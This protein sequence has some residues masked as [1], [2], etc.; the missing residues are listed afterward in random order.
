M[1]SSSISPVPDKVAYYC[2]WGSPY[3]TR[4]IQSTNPA[5]SYSQHI[6]ID[7]TSSHWRIRW[8]FI[9][10]FK[11][12]EITAQWQHERCV[13]ALRKKTYCQGVRK[14]PS[15]R[16]FFSGNKASSK[17]NVCN[18][19]EMDV[20]IQAFGVCMCVWDAASLTKPLTQFEL[21]RAVVAGLSYFLAVPSQWI[22]R[23]AGADE[24][25]WGRHREQ[26][27]NHRNTTHHRSMAG[28][29]Q[30]QTCSK[31]KL[32]LLSPCFMEGL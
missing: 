8:L 26:S 22:E 3:N 32:S 12:R 10:H 24:Q 5:P 9:V 25:T 28:S 21:V 29:W 19:C 13:S 27:G 6:F 1:K 31:D 11:H 4:C 17:T 20:Y 16:C 14:T 7:R 23:T 2:L 30:E 15:Y 18:V